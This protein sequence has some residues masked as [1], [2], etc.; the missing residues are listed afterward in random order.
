[1]S[2]LHTLLRDGRSLLPG[3]SPQIRGSCS[4]ILWMPSAGPALPDADTTV[5]LAHGDR[6]TC[7]GFLDG[8]D[9]DGCPQWRDVTAELLGDVY[10]W[11]ELPIGPA[12]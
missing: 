8:H 1:M 6:E 2:G 10:A 4:T 12:R 5:L 9:D 11:A 3:E 7:E